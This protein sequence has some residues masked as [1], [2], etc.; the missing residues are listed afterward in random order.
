MRPVDEVR[1]HSDAHYRVYVA[2]NELDLHLKYFT[3]IRVLVKWK[4]LWPLPQ[5]KT[6]MK[7]R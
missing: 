6:R 5:S 3:D 4:S 7:G 1:S 2:V